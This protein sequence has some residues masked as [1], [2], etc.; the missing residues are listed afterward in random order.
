MKLYLKDLAER[1]QYDD[2]TF[3][4]KFQYFFTKKKRRFFYIAMMGVFYHYYQRFFK[5]IK[6][7]RERLVIK[8]KK[9]WINRYN[10]QA[11]IY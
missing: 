5:W 7:R 4:T 3:A 9:R 10:P 2:L 6:N 8:Y 1:Q 11:I